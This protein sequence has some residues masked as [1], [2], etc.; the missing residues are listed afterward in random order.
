MSHS[1]GGIL[2]CQF[3]RAFFEGVNECDDDSNRLI[4]MCLGF[5]NVFNK[6]LH[7]MPLNKQ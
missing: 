4:V 1:E 6:D 3:W 7:E 2:T 5:E